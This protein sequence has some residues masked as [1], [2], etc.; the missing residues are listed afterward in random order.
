MRIGT[1]PF[2]APVEIAFPSNKKKKKASK[3]EVHIP[4][5]PST[6]IARCKPE[7]DWAAHGLPSSVLKIYFQLLREL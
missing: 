2:S 4:L 6:Y 7:G 3:T 1:A 5:V